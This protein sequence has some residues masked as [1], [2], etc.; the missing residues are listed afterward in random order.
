M[1]KLYAVGDYIYPSEH[2]ELMQELVNGKLLL[3]IL[4]VRESS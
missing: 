4:S 1:Y 3:L 2:V